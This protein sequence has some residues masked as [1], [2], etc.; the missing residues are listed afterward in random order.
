MSFPRLC[1][2]PYWSPRL[3]IFERVGFFPASM[4]SD[5][6]HYEANPVKHMIMCRKLL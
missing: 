3:V 4:I 6:A 1:T 2:S 5:V